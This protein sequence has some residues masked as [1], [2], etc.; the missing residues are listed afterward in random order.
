MLVRLGRFVERSRMLPTILSAYQKGLDTS[1]AL[2][3]VSHL[4]QSAVEDG[5][6]P[7]IGSTIMG[8]S[9]SSL[10][11]VWKVLC[12]LYQTVSFKSITAS[13]GGGL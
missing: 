13:Y 4:L 2:L 3:C 8:F 12:F 9:I 7:S 1:D 11:W 5:R 10:L 6:Q